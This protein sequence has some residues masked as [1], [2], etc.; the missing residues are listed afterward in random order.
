MNVFKML[1]VAI[2]NYIQNFRVCFLYGTLIPF[3]IFLFTG[4]PEILDLFG[5]TLWPLKIISIPFSFVSTFILSSVS[6]LPVLIA[7]TKPAPDGPFT[8][9]ERFSKKFLPFTLLHVLFLVVF[10]IASAILILIGIV[11]FTINAAIGSEI[12]FIVSLFAVIPIALFLSFAAES[13]TLYSYIAIS[14]EN[15]KVSTAF[16]KGFKM[17]FGNFFRSLGHYIFFGFVTEFIPMIFMRLTLHFAR[18]FIT[19]SFLS[20]QD[21]VISIVFTVITFFLVSLSIPVFYSCFVELYRKN[22]L[23][24]HN[25]PITPPQ[26]EE[27]IFETPDDETIYL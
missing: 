4:V 18:N 5:Y 24:E 23:K 20:I 10:G 27:E 17:F 19:A 15:I 26:T 2:K 1:K 8:F 21:A 7:L 13:I 25:I 14:T 11:Y 9:K 3:A 6:V 12:G 22:W 16:T